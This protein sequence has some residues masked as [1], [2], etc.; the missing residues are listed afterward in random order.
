MMNV[1][2]EMGD[3]LLRYYTAKN[4]RNKLLKHIYA[5]AFTYI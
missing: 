4:I 3:Q 2:L 1:Q 5:K